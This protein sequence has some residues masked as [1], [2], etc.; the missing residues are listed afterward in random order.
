VLLNSSFLLIAVSAS[1]SFSADPRGTGFP[2]GYDAS[3]TKF[4]LFNLFFLLL[5]V[6]TAPPAYTTPTRESARTR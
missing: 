4:V 1:V 2:L 5:A 3:V 6:R